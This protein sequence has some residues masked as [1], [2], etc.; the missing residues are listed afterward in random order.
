MTNIL[1]E[2]S[3]RNKEWLRMAYKICGCYESSKDLVQDMYL[4][5]GL[6]NPELREEH[7]DYVYKIMKNIILNNER[8]KYVNQTKMLNKVKFV[9]IDTNLL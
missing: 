5:I 8:K 1:L 4:R 9:R 3:K 7:S 2:L 6:K